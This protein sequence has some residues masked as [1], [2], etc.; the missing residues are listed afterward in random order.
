[1]AEPPVIIWENDVRRLM[2]HRELIPRLEDALG[3]FSRR[4]SAD[5]IQPVR[6]TVVLQK[7]G[8]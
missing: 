7:P 1:M 3:K 6:T 5:V 4:D 8:G 2:Q